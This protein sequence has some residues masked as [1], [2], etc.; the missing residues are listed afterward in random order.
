MGRPEG[1]VGIL[2]TRFDASGI[3]IEVTLISNG[4]RQPPPNDGNSTGAR[5]RQ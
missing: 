2:A 1:D 3:D 4:R 5:T